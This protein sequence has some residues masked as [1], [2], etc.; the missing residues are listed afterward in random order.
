MYMYIHIHIHTY[1]YTIG[2]P[3]LSKPAELYTQL[4]ALAPATFGS[5]K[6]F[7][8]RYCAAK[9]T[10]YGLDTSGASHLME[11]HTVLYATVALR[12]LKSTILP[13]LPAKVPAP[14]T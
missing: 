4:S 13:D 10:R 3:A 8:N 1:T 6:T 7:A 14:T 11:L 2:T 5:F 9:R 12:R